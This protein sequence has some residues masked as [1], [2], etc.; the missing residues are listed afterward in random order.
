MGLEVVVG[1][2]EGA[3]VTGALVGFLVGLKLG[4]VVTGRL[5]GVF[6]GAGVGAPGVGERVGDSAPVPV[7]KMFFI[8]P[9]ALIWL[10]PTF[11]LDRYRL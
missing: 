10:L 9:P 1:A 4:A 7:I 11:G 5:V 8:V 3:V 2:K 6:E